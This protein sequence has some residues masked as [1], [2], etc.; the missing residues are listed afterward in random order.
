MLSALRET[1]QTHIDIEFT[2]NFL[3]DGSYKINLL[4]CRP[5]QVKSDDGVAAV[6]PDIGDE[7]I[8]LEAR[9]GV[10]GHSRADGPRLAPAGGAVG[11]RQAVGKRPL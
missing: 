5:L 11:L 2:A 1:Y 7:Q 9:G 10:V 3:P 6:L 4:Q 8:V